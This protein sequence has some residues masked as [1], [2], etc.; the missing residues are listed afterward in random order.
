[1][2]KKQKSIT[3][4]L[5]SVV[6]IALLVLVWQVLSMSGV[7]PAFMLPS[8]KQV[9]DAFLS[10][11]PVLIGH[12]CVTLQEAFL[13]LGIG[14]VLSVLLA[15]WMEQ[16]AVIRKAVYPILVISQTIPVVAIAPLL[17]LWLGYGIAPKITLVVMTCFF[18]ITVALLGGF[19][20]ADP[21]A[22]LL[23][24]AMGAN[25]LQIWWHVKLPAAVPSFFSGLKIS[26]SYSVVGAVIA[27]WLGGSNGLGVYMTRVRK[28]YAFDNMFAVIFWIILISLLLIWLLDLLERKTRPWEKE[29]NQKS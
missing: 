25:D 9:L 6:L 20:S 18:P 16:C 14:I 15:F 27:E 21:D 4:K 23:L 12:S 19:Q 24:K 7:I 28:A 2:N 10:E 26:V 1:M 8:P 3:N 13:G 5:Y 29:R 11:F 22:I 17:V